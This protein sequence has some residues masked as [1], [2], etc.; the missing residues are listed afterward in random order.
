[1]AGNS[2]G[3]KRFRDY[4]VRALDSNFL[5]GLGLKT[6]IFRRVFGQATDSGQDL[7]LPRF[8]EILPFLQGMTTW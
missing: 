6:R 5:G 8:G 3:T 4:E 2:E 7:E 1:M